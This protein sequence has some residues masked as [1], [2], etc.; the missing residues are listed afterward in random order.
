MTQLQRKDR[1]RTI[2]RTR[3]I[4]EQKR[5]DRN[6]KTT[7]EMT[8]SEKRK[9]TFPKQKTNQNHSKLTY[10]LVGTFTCIDFLLFFRNS[11]QKHRME[12]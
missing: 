11:Y 6:L 5:I 2:M 10:T 3:W 7:N 8:E 4:E 1:D 12:E 9:E